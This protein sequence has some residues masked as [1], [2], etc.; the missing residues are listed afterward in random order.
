MKTKS[1]DCVKMMCEIR[2]RRDE[3]MAPMTSEKRT[4]YI[5]EEAANLGGPR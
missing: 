1:F 3:E 5:R 2:D 4:R